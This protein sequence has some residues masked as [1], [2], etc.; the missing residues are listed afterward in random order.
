MTATFKH[1]KTVILREESKAYVLLKVFLKFGNR[2]RSYLQIS[3]F[4]VILLIA[5]FK[6][7]INYSEEFLLFL[8]IESG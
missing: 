8:F 5:K 4:L 3:N 2:G 1:F 6:I 7:L